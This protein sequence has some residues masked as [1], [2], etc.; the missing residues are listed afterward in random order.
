M[1]PN[2]T[3]HHP[4]LTTAWIIFSIAAIFYFYDFLLRLAPAVMMDEILASYNISAEEFGLLESSFYFT[5]IPV[6][7]FAGPL[8]DE[9][10]NRKILPI[11]IAA[12]LIGTLL[13]ATELSFTFLI[14]AR[15]LIGLGSS[16]AFAA[17]LKTA[18][19]WFPSPYYSFLA[20]LTTTLGMLGGVVAEVLLPPIIDISVTLFYGLATLIAV[21]L[22]VLARI[23][24]ADKEDPSRQEN[25]FMVLI[26][27][28]GRVLGSLRTWQIGL[29]GC[30]LFTPI[31]LFVTWS[32]GFFSQSMQITPMQAGEI[33]SLVF[34]GL[35]LAAPLIGWLVNY[36]SK[37]VYKW[38]LVLGSLLSLV[39]MTIILYLPHSL[40]L[41]QMQIMVF[42]LGIST[43]VQPLVF[44]LIKD[45]FDSHISATAVTGVNMIINLSSYF[46]PIIGRMIRGN[47]PG[48][49]KQFTLA[50]WQHGLQVILW[51]LALSCILALTLK[52]HHFNQ[53]HT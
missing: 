53:D 14:I 13:A 25:D 22:L 12:C 49:I 10:G 39:L 33:S 2:Q 42:L 8:I 17:V 27:D 21:L 7:L 41:T 20:G 36:F 40:S 3:S 6:Q 18:A 44:V 46:Q 34:W 47:T 35:G 30:G 19:D 29:I 5:Y 32:K 37:N 16:F 1:S 51:L 38:T 24:I 52:P 28:I 31:Q 45:D 43:A 4:S 48:D 11:A 9:Y 50:S 15:M 26:K 23:Y